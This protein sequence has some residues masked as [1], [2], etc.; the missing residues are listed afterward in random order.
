MSIFKDNS[1]AYLY[2]KAEK[3]VTALYMVTNFMATEEPI[4]WQ[5]RRTCIRLLDSIMA[6]SRTTL[7]GREIVTREVVGYLHQ[8]KSLFGVSFKS[9]FISQ[10]NYEIIDREISLLADYLSEYDSNQ[11][12]VQSKLFDASFFRPELPKGQKSKGHLSDSHLSIKDTIKDTNF[13]LSDKFKKT[14]MIKRTELGNRTGDL[15]ASDK[16]PSKNLKDSARR[17]EILSVLKKR[18][19]SSLKDIFDGMVSLGRNYSEKTLQRELSALVEEG[20]VR[21]KGER[22]WSRYFL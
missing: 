16:K 6:L 14:E 15:D 8:V 4:K 10:M 20:V 21:K 18:G 9:G 1:F 13:P 19:E 2:S 17:E 11:L 12:S 5:I 7:S 3:I 22:R